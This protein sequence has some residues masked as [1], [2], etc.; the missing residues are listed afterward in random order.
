MFRY[1][2]QVNLL[3]AS[4]ELH[5]AIPR[6]SIEIICCLITAVLNLMPFILEKHPVFR[7]AHNPKFNFARDER[8]RKILVA[9]VGEI[10]GN[11]E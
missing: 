7:L 11:L 8:N 6:P 3:P 1:S 2:A 5:L 4:S 9:L 10:D